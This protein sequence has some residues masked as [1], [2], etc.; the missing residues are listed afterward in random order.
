M[1][2][3]KSVWSSW[4]YLAEQSDDAAARVSVTYWMNSLQNLPCRAGRV[5]LA[6]PACA[7][8]TRGWS[9][10]RS[11]TPIRC[12][13]APLSPPRA[14]MGEIQ[15]H[16]G[17]WYAGA[18]LGHGFHEDG[19]RSAVAVARALG[20]A[21][22]WEPDRRRC[23]VPW[24]CSRGRR[25]SRHDA[26]AP[27]FLPLSGAGHAP[28]AAAGAVTA[29]PTGS[30]RCSW[31]STRP[32]ELDRRLRLLSIERAQSAQLSRRR[33]WRPRRLAVEALGAG[34]PGRGRY[35]RWHGPASGCSASRDCSATCSTRS[36]STS[37]TRTSGWR[38][39]STRSRTPSAASTSTRSRCSAPAPATGWQR[40]AAPRSSTSR[41]SSTW[42]RATSSTWPSRA[43]RLAVVIKETE[44]GLPL[45]IASQSGERLPL[46]RS[47][48]LALSCR[49]ISS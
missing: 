25:R 7:S 42:R 8:R 11:T 18:W 34:A 48:D 22:P 28:P 2:R 15:G 38:R 47:R 40:M 19:L 49:R 43:D 4:N 41:R 21:P 35:R 44:R 26:P 32:T 10:P 24:A 46:D 17:V 12:S 45:L 1:P 5:R 14:R 13:I 31:T 3:R 23:R 20:V 29:S 6:Q 30:S 36:A 27:T 39:S 33:P 16:G 37:A 9:M